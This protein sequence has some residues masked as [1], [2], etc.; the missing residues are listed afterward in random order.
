M[1][2]FTTEEKITMQMDNARYHWTNEMLQFFNY[3]KVLQHNPLLD[4]GRF[5]LDLCAH[6]PKTQ[7]PR[8]KNF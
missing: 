1:R 8:T 4:I 6:T 3:I 5:V 2:D 7:P